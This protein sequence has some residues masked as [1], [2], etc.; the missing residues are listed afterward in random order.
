MQEERIR[1]YCTMTGLE[2]VEIVSEEGVSAAKPLADRPGGAHLGAI[3]RDQRTGHVV[4]LKLD[5]LFR[6]AA[7]AL[8]RIREWDKSDIALHLVDMGGAAINT[9]TPMGRMM[10]T[11][12]AGFAEWERNVIAERTAA[13]LGHKKA[14]REA[15]SP[16]PLGFRREGNQLLE[17]A[18]EL[19]TVARI[20]QLRAA[21]W[22]FHKIAAQL[23]A[24]S[25]PTKKGGRFHASTVRYILGN[26]LYATGAS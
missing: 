13:V 9:K 6:D 10:I 7:D 17:D 2:L 26:R 11:I 24:D 4:T 5:R 23:N 8:T 18:D 3:I 12:L 19:A 22:S 14:H 25:V 1:A 15:Y 20:Q 16:T 21:G